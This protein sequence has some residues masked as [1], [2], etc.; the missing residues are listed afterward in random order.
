MIGIE[1]S[2]MPRQAQEALA[3]DETRAFRTISSMPEVRQT[4]FD[5][6]HGRCAYC[7][8]ELSLKPGR[9]RIEHFHPQSGAFLSPACSTQ[10][11]AKKAEDAP[12]AWWNLLL[13]CP[14]K[15]DQGQETCDVSKHQKDVCEAIHNPRLM[16]PSTSQV[17]VDGVSGRV[18][19]ANDDDEATRVVDEVLRLN[20]P[21]LCRERSNVWSAVVR[22]LGEM[23]KA[24]ARRHKGGQAPKADVEA[25]LEEAVRTKPFGS[26][27][28]SLLEKKRR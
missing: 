5:A 10:S 3:F 24:A 23:S 12:V 6:Q 18:L 22:R 25:M 1:K 11:G 13:A 27:Y 4:L 2:S 15:G 9:T 7:E 16:T 8:R 21:A 19:A 14:G 28:L 26:V 20:D 17:R